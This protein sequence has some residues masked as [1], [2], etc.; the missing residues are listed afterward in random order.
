[1]PPV[2]VARHVWHAC[3]CRLQQLQGK[4][5]AVPPGAP[6]A[7]ADTSKLSGLIES[8]TATAPSTSATTATAAAAAAPAAAAAAAR[9]SSA[10]SSAGKASTAGGKGAAAAPALSK[11]EQVGGCTTTDDAPLSHPCTRVSFQHHP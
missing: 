9:V 3:L 2:C 10:A 8:L 5:V 7:M 1:M 4:P 11:A 6:A